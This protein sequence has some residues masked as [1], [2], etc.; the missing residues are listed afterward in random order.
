MYEVH[1]YTVHLPWPGCEKYGTFCFE[2]FSQ[3]TVSLFQVFSSACCCHFY[4]A[5]LKNDLKKT[6][7]LS[8]DLKTTW[9][10]S[11]NI[12]NSNKLCPD[13]IPTDATA[14]LEQPCLLLQVVLPPPGQPLE[15]RPRTTQQ[16]L[17]IHI[18]EIVL[19]RERERERYFC[20]SLQHCI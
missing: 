2:L 7:P 12:F 3:F 13:V 15:T 17:Q 16:V 20:T 18:R 19:R 8:L 6:F 10:Q 5:L 4:T 14:H 11:R 9:T 1:V